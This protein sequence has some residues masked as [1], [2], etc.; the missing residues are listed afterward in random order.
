MRKVLQVNIRLSEGGAAG[1]ART[2]S[3]ELRRTGIESPFAYGYGKR[4]GPSPLEDQYSGV[5]ITPGL[6]AAL[7]R[8]T[9]GLLGYDT[10][11]K[12][13][14]L[15]GK[16]ADEVAS[17]DLVHLHA[18]HSYMT[19]ADSLFETLIAAG[20]PVVWTL[21]DQWIM[22]GRCAQPG[23]CRKW[24]TGCGGCPSLTA[25]PPAV[26]DHSARHWKK[27]YQAV[28]EL[29]SS[30]PTAIIACADWLGEEADK[31]GLAN[32]QVIKNSVD[33]VF[34]ESV[35]SATSKA[36]PKIR[37]LFICRDLRDSLKV[38]W[39]LIERVANLDGQT[40]TVIG[41]NPEALPDNVT[42]R[43]AITDRAELAKAMVAHDRLIFSSRVDYF[44]LTIAEA[45]TAG[46]RV[47]A[48]DS[49]AAR[50]FQDHPRVE[51]ASDEDALVRLATDLS[52]GNS[53][54]STALER[55]FFDPERM[56]REYIDVYRRLLRG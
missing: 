18:V 52:A 32:V 35:N 4:G 37:N 30:L 31:A 36:D 40:T 21:H 7:N 50:E 49:R 53:G 6:V 20:K 14:K 19:S 44:P 24:E 9:Y 13:P 28:R 43:P 55:S 8:A 29:Q 12:S 16:F 27:R 2:L 41:D 45:L 56:S 11:L 1:V 15:W 23:D 3:D 47:L 26:F 38:S 51:I 48:L 54:N 22:T 10:S 34:W 46:L 5:R 25:Y 33:R 17:S 42:H 39:P